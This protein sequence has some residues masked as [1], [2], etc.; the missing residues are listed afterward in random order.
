MNPSP[1]TFFP[2]PVAGGSANPAQM[3][4]HIPGRPWSSVRSSLSSRLIS[5][6]TRKPLQPRLCFRKATRPNEGMLFRLS[7]RFKIT[8][9]WMKN[10]LIPPVLSIPGCSG[11]DRQHLGDASLRLTSHC[12]AGS[13]PSTRLEMSSGVGSPRRPSAA[14]RSPACQRLRRALK[15]Y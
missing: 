7:A 14:R 8:A 5:P 11:Q 13:R 1:K 12:A 3:R 10:T 2:N 15:R 4:S 6:H 9:C